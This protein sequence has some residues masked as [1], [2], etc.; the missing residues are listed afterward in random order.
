MLRRAKRLRP[1]FDG[2]YAQYSRPDPQPSQE[3]WRQIDNLLAI[4]QPFFTFTE[5]PSR[6][7]KISLSYYLSIYNKLFSHL[8]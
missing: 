3:E 8:E 1:I 6:K 7:P 4:T 2:F 5:P